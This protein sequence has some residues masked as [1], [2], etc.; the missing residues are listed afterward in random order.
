[1]LEV[2]KKNANEP[3]RA[4]LRKTIHFAVA[5]VLIVAFLSLS[6]LSH[7]AFQIIDSQ[8]W[9][10]SGGNPAVY[11]LD[12]QRVL[13]IGDDNAKRDWTRD[14]QL[15]LFS[16][17]IGKPRVLIRRGVDTVCYRPGQILY[18]VWDK[19]AKT[20]TFY[21]GAF[22][23]EVAVQ[24]KGF[25]GITCDA[26]HGPDRSQNRSVLPLLPGHGYL[27]MGPRL[28]K[29]SMKNTPVMLFPE[30]AT[31]GIP[32][33]FGRREG[34]LARYYHFR[35]AYF[36]ELAYFDPAKG[37][38]STT[39]PKNMSRIAYWMWP[40]GHTERVEFPND[41]LGARPTKAGIAYRIFGTGAKDGVY[42]LAP[43]GD[44]KLV[45][46]GHVV[47]LAISPDGCRIALSHSPDEKSFMRGPQNKR[48]LKVV[49][50]C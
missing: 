28:G 19:Q 4:I 35:G 25:N 49:E 8:S 22:G 48:T 40:D 14:A 13:Y 42:L 12:T 50:I 5:A 34:D 17:E 2:T 37:Y 30:G 31:E 46:Q 11:W 15:A 29:E 6:P 27:Y 10:M 41:I 20:R 44:R 45:I 26:T 36:F 21:Q 7:A 38:S 3:G 33:P 47:D 16:W 43:N 23:H 18:V 32:L 24:T 9:L 39:W 1:M